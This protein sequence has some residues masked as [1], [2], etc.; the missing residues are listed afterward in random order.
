MQTLFL[1]VL[2]DYSILKSVN[3][4]NTDDKIKFYED[5]L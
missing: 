4:L 2:H 3:P 1:G 5:D